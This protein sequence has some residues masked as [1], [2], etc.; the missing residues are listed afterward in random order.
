MRLKDSVLINEVDGQV[1]AVDM[2]GQGKRF[3]GMLRMNKTAGFVAE[4]MKQEI[5]LDEIVKA[6]I[7]KYSVT[8]DVA[9][10]NAQK[11]IDAFTGAGL[12]D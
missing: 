12:M 9:K 4:L 1:F 3:N 6:I 7:E 11:V 2:G 5:S 10:R 8:E